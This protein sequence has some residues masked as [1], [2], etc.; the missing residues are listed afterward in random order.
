MDARGWPQEYFEVVLSGLDCTSTS[1]TSGASPGTPATSAGSAKT[2]SVATTPRIWRL[3]G[4][5]YAILTGSNHP[6]SG[7]QVFD[8]SASAL[9]RNLLG[10]PVN[11]RGKPFV[12]IVGPARLRG[13]SKSETLSLLR[14][15]TVSRP[16]GT[17]SSSGVSSVNGAFLEGPIGKCPGSLSMASMSVSSSKGSGGKISSKASA[18]ASTSTEDAS[19]GEVSP[20]HE[21]HAPPG[22]CVS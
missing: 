19:L 3:P 16:S 1:R 20:C 9:Q 14:D 8:G 13:S 2:L 12:A 10:G 7:V 21:S 22:P 5:G 17:E 15:T 18:E 6:I 4:R 11:V